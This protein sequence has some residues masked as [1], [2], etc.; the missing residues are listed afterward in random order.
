MRP[1]SEPPRC[2]L[3]WFQIRQFSAFFFCHVVL[4]LRR[5]TFVRSTGPTRHPRDVSR[6]IA[7]LGLAAPLYFFAGIV[8]P[9]DVVWVGRPSPR[10]HVILSIK[11]TC[12]FY[13]SVG[14]VV[15]SQTPAYVH[16]RLGKR[17]LTT[18]LG[19][20][21]LSFTAHVVVSN[22][23]DVPLYLVN[24]SSCRGRL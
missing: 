5:Q 12:I 14:M 20:L 21:S 23:K 9:A 2:V 13:G 4:V 22:V 16:V 3:R 18:L 6:K 8:T 10:D 17:H 19:C 11:E 7:G 15:G 24:G 1:V